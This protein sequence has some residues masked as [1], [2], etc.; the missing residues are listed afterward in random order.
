MLYNL[1]YLYFIFFECNFNLEAS[2][3]LKLDIIYNLFLVPGQTLVF[4]LGKGLV[5][6]TKL[7]IVNSNNK[8]YHKLLQKVVLG[9]DKTLEFKTIKD[10]SQSTFNL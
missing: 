9:T 2:I 8:H 7:Y 6:R 4:F 3:L 5:L 1:L 10:G